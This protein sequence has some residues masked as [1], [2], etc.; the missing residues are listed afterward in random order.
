MKFI[1]ALILLQLFSAVAVR[2]QD[3]DL[4]YPP[5]EMSVALF[6]QKDFTGWT[7]VTKTN[8]DPSQTWS[9]TNGM[10]HCTGAPT[11]YIRTTD[12]KSTRL[13]SSH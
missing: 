11:G 10:I 5:H 9:V 7:F 12:R 6:N 3:N 13:N 2:A 1:A 8:T 4:R